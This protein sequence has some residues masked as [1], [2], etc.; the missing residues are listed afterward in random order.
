MNQDVIWA[1]QRPQGDRCG[2]DFTQKG[3]TAI[4]KHKFRH[5]RCN[6]YMHLR[7]PV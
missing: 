2:V 7:S 3:Y 1:E 4:R 5:L 6:F